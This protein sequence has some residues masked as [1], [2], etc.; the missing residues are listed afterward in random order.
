MEFKDQWDTLVLAS[1]EHGPSDLGTAWHTSRLW[2]R[3]EAET[4]IISSTANTVVVSLTF[5]FLG[6]L[7][8]THCDVMLSVMVILSVV[9]VTVCLMFFMSVMM[10][11]AM[12]AVEVLGLIVFIGYSITYSLHVAHKYREHSMRTCGSDLDKTNRRHAAVMHAMESM[13]SA[14]VGSAVTTLGSSFF[15]FFCTMA[16]FVKL[17]SVLFAV[18]FFAMV[19]SIVILPAALLYIGP[20]SV[21]GCGV[22]AQMVDGVRDMHA[23]ASGPQGMGGEVRRQISEEPVPGAEANQPFCQGHVEP[24]DSEIFIASND[25]VV[26][27][28]A[29]SLSASPSPS[30]SLPAASLTGQQRLSIVRASASSEATVRRVE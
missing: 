26:G 17:A 12:G 4:A 5:G 13:S 10:A 6:A 7:S 29:T 8:F 27:L 25:G 19:F 2:I 15:L 11:W 14:V 16:I 9:G 30:P 3:A 22:I 20:L 21:C 23:S 24:R 28:R 18:T 1:N